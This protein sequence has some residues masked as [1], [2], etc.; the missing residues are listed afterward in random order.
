MA[1]NPN[2]P[3]GEIAGR[4]RL[5]AATVIQWLSSPCGQVFLQE[6]GEEI[7]IEENLDMITD[8]YGSFWSVTCLECGQDTMH[9]VRPGRVQC[10]NCE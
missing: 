8:G 4:D 1:E 2:D 5:V 6:V 7:F 9:V 10:A 3:E